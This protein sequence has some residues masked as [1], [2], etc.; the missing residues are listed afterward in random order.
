MASFDFFLR[1]NKNDG[2]ERWT[3]CIMQE[4]I[5]VSVRY[6]VL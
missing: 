3:S 6:A 5:K 4:E 2:G 1:N